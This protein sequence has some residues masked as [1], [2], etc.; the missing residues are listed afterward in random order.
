MDDLPNHTDIEA[1]LRRYADHVEDQVGPIP[2][3]GAT[4]RPT[5]SRR[6]RRVTTT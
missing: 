6:V 5:S 4:R 1:Q 3:F 2:P